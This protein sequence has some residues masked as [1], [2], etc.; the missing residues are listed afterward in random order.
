MRALQEGLITEDAI[1]RHL[2][3][4]VKSVRGKH[5]K[6]RFLRGW[7]DRLVLLQGGRV[8]FFELKRPKGGKYEP[9]Q[10]RVH[11]A[12]RKMGFRV[13]VC[14]TKDAINNAIQEIES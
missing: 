1:E 11:E 10:L 4:W 9:L 5:I 8:V 12:L 6:I 7:P 13:Y 14:H 3:R 2:I